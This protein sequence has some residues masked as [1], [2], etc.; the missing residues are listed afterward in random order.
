MSEGKQLS[1]IIIITFSFYFYFTFIFVFNISMQNSVRKYKKP[2]HYAVTK[3]PL[4][5][6]HP[7]VGLP[8]TNSLY[9]FPSLVLYFLSFFSLFFSLS[10]FSEGRKDLLI[11]E[12]AQEVGLVD[13]IILF[14]ILLYPPPF[15]PCSFLSLPPFPCPPFSLPSTLL[16]LSLFILRATMGQTLGPRQFSPHS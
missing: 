1:W 2:I 13:I 3:L 12:L 6:S 8:L 16:P 4:S 10:S 9:V 14:P 11:R 7:L 5:L 15:P